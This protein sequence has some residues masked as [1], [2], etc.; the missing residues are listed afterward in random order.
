MLG[1]WQVKWGLI[2]RAG[3]EEGEVKLRPYLA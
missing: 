3:D 2:T 1:L